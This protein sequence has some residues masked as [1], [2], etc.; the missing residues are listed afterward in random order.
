MEMTRDM[1]MCMQ[2]IRRRLRAETGL[3]IRISQP[4]AVPRMLEVC[5]AS[6]SN[7]SRRLGERLGELTGMAPPPPPPPPPAPVAIPAPISI[8]VSVLAPAPVLSAEALEE[9]QL[10]QKYIEARYSGPLRG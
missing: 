7:E 1:I 2:T 5:A 3:D 9:Q 6:V 8:P 10:I 4:D